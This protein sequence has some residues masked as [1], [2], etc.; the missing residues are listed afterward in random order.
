M[1]RACEAAALTGVSAQEP[2]HSF[3]FLFYKVDL[4]VDLMA[5]YRSDQRNFRFGVLF[6]GYE[7]GSG[8]GWGSEGLGSEGL[9]GDLNSRPELQTH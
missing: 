8:F 3:E 9:K 7:T 5:L 1:S 2:S 6:S 4:V